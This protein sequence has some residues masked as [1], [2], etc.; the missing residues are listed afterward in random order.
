MTI[1]HGLCFA[2]SSYPQNRTDERRQRGYELDRALQAARAL[3]ARL[4][5]L[6]DRAGDV[7]AIRVLR[8]SLTRDLIAA[9]AGEGRSESQAT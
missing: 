2:A 7:A 3:Q 5:M 6:G 8:D 9:V 4:E 1:R